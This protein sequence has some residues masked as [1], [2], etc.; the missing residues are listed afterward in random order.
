MDG[1]HPVKATCPLIFWP[2]AVAVPM[3][4]LKT[5]IDIIKKRG[6]HSTDV[7]FVHTEPAAQGLIPTILICR[8]EL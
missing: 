4:H 3:P 5:Q 8:S 7:M 1:F 2:D 6:R